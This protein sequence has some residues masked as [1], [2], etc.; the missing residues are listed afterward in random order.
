MRVLRSKKVL[1]AA[2]APSP[3]AS[4]AIAISATKTQV[5][6]RHD[7]GSPAIQKATLDN[8]ASGWH[9]TRASWWSRVHEGSLQPS[10]R[11]CTPKTGGAGE[12]PPSRAPY[13][14]IPRHPPRT[15]RDGH[16]HLNGPDQGRS[17]PVRLQPRLQ[18]LFR[19]SRRGRRTD[20]GRGGR[21]PITKDGR[22]GPLGGPARVRVAVGKSGAI[23][24][25]P[26][27]PTLQM[28]ML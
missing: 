25:E 26:L 22:A 20:S 10:T 23:R 28:L 16:L 14:P 5:I 3:R 4:A 1:V 2:T 7:R 27:T 13:Q 21:R 17:S 19:R 6:H 18:P 8:Y 11:R 9:T 24:L 12:K 15:P